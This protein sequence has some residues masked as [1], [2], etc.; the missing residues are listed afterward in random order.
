MLF[1]IYV[2]FNSYISFMKSFV[3]FLLFLLLIGCN[4]SKISVEN[5][6]RFKSEDFKLQVSHL[7][8][9]LKKSESK[10]NEIS[11][12]LAISKN[13]TYVQVL[14]INCVP[15]ESYPFIENFNGI[16]VPVYVHSLSQ[17]PQ[18]VINMNDLEILQ[19]VTEY[20]YC[21][22]YLSLSARFSMKGDVLKLE[23]ILTNYSNHTESILVEEDLGVF[24]EIIYTILPEP[25]EGV[26]IEKESE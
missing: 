11:I 14:G 1:G 6:K 16:E 2:N 19:N 18:R 3:L 15:G 4:S 8:P 12:R 23:K 26:Q 20:T 9:L 13:Y 7:I 25:I 21:D 22:D 5:T 17:E 24:G 10:S